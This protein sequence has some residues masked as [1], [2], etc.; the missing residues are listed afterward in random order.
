M[1]GATLTGRGV[2]YL[3]RYWVGPDAF[4]PYLDNLDGEGNQHE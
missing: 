3:L 4:G 2:M 1:S